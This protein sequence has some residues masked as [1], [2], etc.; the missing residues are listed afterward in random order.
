MN[1]IIT[2]IVL[3]FSPIPDA[4]FQDAKGT[5]ARLESLMEV[6]K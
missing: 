4:V 5:T 6:V 3:C 2:A 1:N